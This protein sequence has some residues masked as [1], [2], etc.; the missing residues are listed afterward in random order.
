MSRGNGCA[1]STDVI[2]RSD[3][4]RTRRRAASAAGLAD[5]Q[6]TQKDIAAA[7]DSGVPTRKLIACHVWGGRPFLYLHANGQGACQV[8]MS[9]I[10]DLQHY[11]HPAHMHPPP[12]ASLTN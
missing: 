8:L 4:G 7:V 9:S 6:C 12:K 3:S 1:K 5:R 2:V 11:S 10:E